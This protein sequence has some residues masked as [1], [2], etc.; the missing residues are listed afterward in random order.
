[1][2]RPSEK[3]LMRSSNFE[4]LRIAAMLMIVASHAAQHS[5]R[6]N[7]DL[8]ARP[9]NLNVIFLYFAGTCGQLGVVI[10][11][12]ISCWFLCSA[13]SVRL[14]KIGGIYLQTMISSL[15]IFAVI[16]ISGAEK[17]G[18]RDFLHSILTPLWNG[19]WFVRTYLIFL[20]FVPFLQKFVQSADEKTHKNLFVVFTIILPFARFFFP[21]AEEFGTL[22]DFLYIFAAVS[23]LKKHDGNFLER[24][25]A[26]A[27]VLFFV[28]PRIFMCILNFVSFKFG[29][30][31][32]IFLKRILLHVFAIRHILTMISGMSFFYIFKNRVK[33][34]ANFFV[35]SVA[36]TTLG[37]YIFHENFLLRIYGENDGRTA[38]LFER[39]LG[40]G[41]NFDGGK[42]F[43]LY[44]LLCVAAVFVA[45]SLLESFR[46]I[47]FSL[48]SRAP[49]LLKK[50][51]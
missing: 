29:L 31:N 23:Y 38:L 42:F 22:G 17:V 37:V 6:G 1:M 21:I 2:N 40:I 5:A 33:I 32:E 24:N 44:F 12:I 26:A 48:I 34:G 35:N 41:A 11:V 10:F 36:K 18:A 49:A 25:S 13:N 28:F 43:A 16:K 46:R 39:I 50:K 9:L 7:F 45:C 27:F 47:L 30:M 19:Y 15:A 14:K 20:L 51:S 8:I 3:K 4:L